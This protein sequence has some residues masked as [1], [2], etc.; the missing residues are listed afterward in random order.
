[1]PSKADEPLG[2][3]WQKQA[4]AKPPWLCQE[5][6]QKPRLPFADGRNPALAWRFLAAIDAFM[7]FFGK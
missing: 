5:K 2:I 7:G 6:P 3:P 4:L 1:L